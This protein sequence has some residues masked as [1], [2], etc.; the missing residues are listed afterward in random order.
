MDRFHTNLCTTLYDHFKN[1]LDPPINS[2]E[3]KEHLKIN[4]EKLVL[5]SNLHVFDDGDVIWKKL[6][7]NK[8]KFAYF[9]KIEFK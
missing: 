7:E 6:A 4:I 2:N 9:N 8:H 1:G 5:N 3:E